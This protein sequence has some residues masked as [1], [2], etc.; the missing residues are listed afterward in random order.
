MSSPGSPSG[1]RQLAKVNTPLPKEIQLPSEPVPL[2][3]NE[4]KRLTA[5]QSEDEDD[6]A[7]TGSCGANGIPHEHR[8][9]GESTKQ[10]LVQV[11]DFL[12]AVC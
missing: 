4:M 7:S 5:G 2:D 10:I 9:A 11:R 12:K 8:I 1:Q 3:S 6:V